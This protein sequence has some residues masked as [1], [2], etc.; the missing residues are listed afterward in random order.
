MQG[1][2]K[3]TFLLDTIF[4]WTPCLRAGPII[5]VLHIAVCVFTRILA[6]GIINRLETQVKAICGAFPWCTI[7]QGFFVLILVGS[8]CFNIDPI[9]LHIL[10]I[11]ISPIQGLRFTCGMEPHNNIIWCVCLFKRCMCFPFI[12]C[13]YGMPKRL[14]TFSSTILNKASIN[15]F[16]YY[17]LDPAKPHKLLYAGLMAA[18]S[19]SCTNPLP[20]HRLGDMMDYTYVFAT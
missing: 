2:L 1:C 13:L 10:L 11:L 4:V 19:N 16:P 18:V 9:L 8:S 12:R 17:L 6:D 7:Y 14:P 20:E 5:H 3:S 15:T